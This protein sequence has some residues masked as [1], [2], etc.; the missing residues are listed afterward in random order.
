MKKI[1]WDRV[2]RLTWQQVRGA[3]CS[4]RE[5]QEGDGPGGVPEMGSAAVR[6]V[7][8]SESGRELHET[9]QGADEPVQDALAF[10]GC[11]AVEHDGADGIRDGCARQVVDVPAS[12][13][14]GG[15]VAL[16]ARMQ[17]ASG[18]AGV[19]VPSGREGETSQGADVQ[20]GG[21]FE[22]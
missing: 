11:S 13:L 1:N 10:L 15:E 16:Q 14:A 20:P 3:G 21:D 8:R 2:R 5:L 4:G 7:A 18:A 6:T 17:V 19:N 22:T 12:L 9:E